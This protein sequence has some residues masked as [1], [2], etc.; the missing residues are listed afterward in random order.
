MTV[1]FTRSWLFNAKIKCMGRYAEPGEG[2][3]SKRIHKKLED[4][5][6]GEYTTLS[7]LSLATVFLSAFVFDTGLQSFYFSTLRDIFSSG[8]INIV[9]FVLLSI[10]V[11]AAV[12]YILLL[13]TRTT[14][15]TLLYIAA[16]IVISFVMLFVSVEYFIGTVPDGPFRGLI[17][18]LALYHLCS[19]VISFRVA[20][21]DSRYIDSRIKMNPNKPFYILFLV[22]IVSVASHILFIG[23][24]GSEL[25]SWAFVVTFNLVVW[26]VLRQKIH[27][28]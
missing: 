21:T 23:I 16:Y 26:S 11:C 22:V 13:C 4:L 27:L 8:T 28:E 14:H 17:M 25:Y 5:F 7:I 20:M 1:L 15:T 2:F 10:A 3:L 19:G 12:T 9:A 24:L 6:F 18:I